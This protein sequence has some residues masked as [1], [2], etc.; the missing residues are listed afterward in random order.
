MTRVGTLCVLPKRFR[1]QF[2][3]SMRLSQLPGGLRATGSFMTC[4]GCGG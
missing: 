4:S 2:S 3:T 1:E